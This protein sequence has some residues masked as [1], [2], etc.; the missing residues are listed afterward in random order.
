LAA[1]LRLKQHNGITSTIYEIRP[2]PTTLGGAV[3]IPSNGLRL[4]HHLGLYDALLSR[5]SSSTDLVIHST[6]DAVIAEMNMVAWSKKKT[7]YGFM[8][9]RR[10]DLIDVLQSAVEKEGI[11]IRFGK[12][13][14]SIQEDDQSVTV[15][16]ADGTIDTA[17]IVLGCDGIHS[18]LRK[19]HVDPQT[20]PEYS[21]I[22]NMFSILSTSA[23]PSGASLAPGLHATQTTTGLFGVMPCTASNDHLYWFYSREVPIPDSGDTRDGWEAYGNKQVESFKNNLLDVLGDVHGQWGDFLKDVVDKTDTIKFYPIYRLPLGTKW[24]TGRCILLGDA[25]HAIQPHAGQGVS[26]AL[27]DVLLLSRLLEDSSQPLLQAFKKFEKIRR[28]RV[29]KIAKASTSNGEARKTI[30][31]WGLALR[32]IA[33]SAGFWVYKTVGLQNWGVGIGQR[34]WAY[35]I[36]EEDLGGGKL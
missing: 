8:R 31:P 18:G 21:G 20:T 14:T 5:G 33:I 29:D 4:L 34:D 15:A 27:E 24:H 26:M 2:H 13:M 12:Q 28:P 35:D 3:N 9:V 36:T 30:G 19:L 17:D 6:Q 10:T 11:T 22:S 25:A 1:A 7:G 16:F 32:E 23:L